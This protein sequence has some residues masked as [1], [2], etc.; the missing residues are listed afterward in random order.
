M[1][2]PIK[3][4]YTTEPPLKVGHLVEYKDP[5]PDHQS[6]LGIV[7]H[8]AEV[9]SN[10][11]ERGYLEA[12]VVWTKKRWSEKNAGKGLSLFETFEDASRLKIL[13]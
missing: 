2:E 10:V 12:E 7:I 13:S 11:Y 3:S 8:V 6:L 9:D 1:I 5:L 4:R